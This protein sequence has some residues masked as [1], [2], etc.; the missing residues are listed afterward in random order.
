VRKET[1]DIPDREK[2]MEDE[3]NKKVVVFSAMVDNPRRA[4]SS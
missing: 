4:P 1:E 3:T 2:K